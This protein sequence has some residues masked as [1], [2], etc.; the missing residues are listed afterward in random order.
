MYHHS[1]RHAEFIH[2]SLY[3]AHS[4]QNSSFEFYSS[5][6]LIKHANMT[7]DKSDY[8]YNRDQDS[9]LHAKLCIMLKKLKH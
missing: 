7:K 6:V 4:E 5:F 1:W 9:G 2:L 8:F 3:E